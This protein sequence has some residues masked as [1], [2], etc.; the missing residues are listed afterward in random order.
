MTDSGAAA[1]EREH[2]D[3]GPIVVEF[4]D[5]V[6]RPRPWTVLQSEWAAELAQHAPAGA[7]LELCA[8]AGHIG[9]AA[10][11][12]TG[13]DLVQVEVDPAAARLAV[14]N[15]ANAGRRTD[16]RVG[17]MEHALSAHERFPIVLADPP[18]L[19]SAEVSAWP[20]DPVRA[21]DGG[22]DGLRLVRM[23]LR[24]AARHLAAGGDVLLQVA[25]AGQAG[26][27]AHELPA[28][29]TIREIRSADER[30]AVMHLQGD[31]G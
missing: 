16:V 27:L 11:V 23:S 3:F 4:D 8:G 20:S 24:V 25:G 5:G 17:S 9:L 14:R 1:R 29:L 18:Y 28:G 21:I 22:P 10:A 6:L 13:R 7:I 31:E 2:M 26:Q 19:P 15:A 30:R 12:L